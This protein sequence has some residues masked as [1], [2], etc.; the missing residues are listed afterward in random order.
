VF[1]AASGSRW[2]PRKMSGSE[3]RRIDWLIVTINTP[4][5]VLERATHLYP[6]PGITRLGYLDS[7]VNV[8]V[9]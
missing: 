5:V 4:S 2:M 9:C 7:D 1:D 8:K 3:M 6:G